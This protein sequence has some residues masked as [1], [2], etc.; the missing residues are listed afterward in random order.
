MISSARASLTLAILVATLCA[1]CMRAGSPPAI[2]RRQHAP[3]P[4]SATVALWHMDERGGTRV[5]DSGPWRMDGTAGV[6]AR[7]RFGRFDNAREFERSLDSFIH[8]PY[9]PMMETRPSFTVEAWLFPRA[10]GRHEDTPIAGRWSEEVN[11]QS[12]LFALGG[13]Q[14]SPSPTRPPGPGYHLALFPQITPGHLLFAYQPAAAGAP[15]SFRS[16]QPLE[17]DRW[18]H[19][20]VAFD[21]EVVRFYIDGLLDSQYAATG[22][23]RRSPAALL[24][25][26]YVDIRRLSRFG[27]DLRLDPSGDSNAYYAF[28]G[29]IDELRISSSAREAFPTIAQP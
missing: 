24:I 13:R 25:G 9:D 7:M 15:Q 6:A 2:S 18:T 1:S 27:G 3:R 19:I 16:S 17:L 14:L 5:A 26:N 10:F 8:V 20:A 23:I 21:G 28:E 29:L 4:D 11:H 12:W 22:G